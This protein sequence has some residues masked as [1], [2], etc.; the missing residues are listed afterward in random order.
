MNAVSVDVMMTGHVLA[1]EVHTEIGADRDAS[2][3]EPG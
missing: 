2:G 3:G 1:R